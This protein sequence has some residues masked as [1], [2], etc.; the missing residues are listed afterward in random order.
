MFAR[1]VGRQNAL[2]CLRISMCLRLRWMGEH[3]LR[4]SLC[5]WCKQALAFLARRSLGN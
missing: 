5:R 2:M 1:H 4:M 3:L